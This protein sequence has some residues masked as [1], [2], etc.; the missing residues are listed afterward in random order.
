M[1]DDSETEP[2]RKIDRKR[3][4]LTKSD[5]EYLLGEKSLDGQ[6]EINT[7]YRIRQRV[8]NS[9]LDIHLIAQCLRQEDKT[10]IVNDKRVANRSTWESVSA[11]AYDL[12]EKNSDTSEPIEIFEDVV[13]KAVGANMVTSDSGGTNI[14]TPGS[15]AVDVAVDIDIEYVEKMTN[16]E[17]VALILSKAHS[18][19]VPLDEAL[20]PF[21]D[22]MR[23]ELNMAEMVKE[24][25]SS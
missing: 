19:D 13:A 21:I 14:S 12:V 7:R 16:E 11:L 20:E 15:M 4:I 5:R 6:D 8:I 25:D 18:M 23:D 2:W 22:E 17:L 3:G 24:R 10:Q 1:A 9:I